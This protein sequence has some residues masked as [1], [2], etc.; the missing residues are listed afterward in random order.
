[1]KNVGNSSR[2]RSQGV[3]NIFMAPHRAHCAVI[4]ATVQLSCLLSSALLDTTVNG[5]LY[6]LYC[7][8]S[9]VRTSPNFSGAIESAS[10]WLWMISDKNHITPTAEP[11]VAASSLQQGVTICRGHFQRERLGT[12]FQKLFW[13]WERRSQERRS[14]EWN[15]PLVIYYTF[16][17]TP[18]FRPNSQCFL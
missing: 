16:V 15:S 9:S 7:C 11:P 2:G 12:T 14:Q 10:D 4:F 3:M 8:I 1:M 18:Q 17:N 13:Q 5:A 6:I